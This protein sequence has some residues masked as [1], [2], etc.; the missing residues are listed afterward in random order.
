MKAEAEDVQ[1]SRL[2]INRHRGERPDEV[3]KNPP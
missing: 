3:L 2:E 1:T